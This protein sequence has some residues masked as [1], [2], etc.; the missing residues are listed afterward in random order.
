MVVI[1]RHVQRSRHFLP[2][3]IVDQYDVQVRHLEM[4]GLVGKLL[5]DTMGGPCLRVPIIM[6]F[7]EQLHG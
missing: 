5:P 4:H 2:G 6:V 3:F 1:V 7:H